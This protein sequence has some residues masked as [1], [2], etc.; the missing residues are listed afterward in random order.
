MITLQG[1]LFPGPDRQKPDNKED[2]LWIFADL[3]S[4]RVLRAYVLQNADASTLRDIVDGL[5][6]DFEVKLVGI[7]SDKQN[8]IT[9]MH[10]AFFPSVPHQYCQFQFLQNLWKHIKMKDSHLHKSL[11]RIVHM[12]PAQTLEFEDRGSTP[13][14]MLFAP[15]EA[16]LKRI[17]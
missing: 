10:N 11:E 1:M 2:T 17:L 12:S 3:L 13:I 5:L 7:V 15:I 6:Q 16:D 8:N 9:N 4:N 14:R